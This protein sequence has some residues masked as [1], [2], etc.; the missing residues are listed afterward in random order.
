MAAVGSGDA[1]VDM[2][3]F[4]VWDA[5][6]CLLGDG[7]VDHAAPVVFYCAG[8]LLQTRQ[9]LRDGQADHRISLGDRYF[10]DDP[11]WSR[12]EIDSVVQGTEELAAQPQGQLIRLFQ[13]PEGDLAVPGQ[14]LPNLFKRPVEIYKHGSAPPSMPS[15]PGTFPQPPDP[16]DGPPECAGSPDYPGHL[17]IPCHLSPQRRSVPA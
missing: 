2:G 13:H 15:H 1:D 3:F 5:G 11:F 7:L 16:P 8:Q 14:V 9:R 10:P 6:F 17:R 12:T 4:E